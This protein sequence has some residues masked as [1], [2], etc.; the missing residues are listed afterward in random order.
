MTCVRPYE[1]M[2]LFSTVEN[3]TGASALVAPVVP[4]V[5]CKTWNMEWNGTW[6]GCKVSLVP[7]PSAPPVFDRL[8]YAGSDQKLEV[9]KA[10]ERG[11]AKVIT[12]PISVLIKVGV[13]W[14]WRKRSRVMV[15]VI[16]S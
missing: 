12:S 2:P 11:Y 15:T 5:A 10:W 13:N 4:T 16:I 8:Q 9:W 3:F 1:G 6:N 7:R 14:S